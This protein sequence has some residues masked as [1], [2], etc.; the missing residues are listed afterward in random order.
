MLFKVEDL[1]SIPVPKPLMVQFLM[2]TPILLS[3]CQFAPYNVPAVFTNDVPV[4]F[5]NDVPAVF[6]NDVP[7]DG[8]QVA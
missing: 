5:T 6:T 7:A 1:I 3:C 2:F 8:K 4:I